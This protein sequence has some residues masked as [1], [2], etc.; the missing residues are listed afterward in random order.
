M[1]DNTERILADIRRTLDETK[2]ILL[3]V[4]QDRIL[5]VKKRL[6]P[7]GTVKFQVYELCDGT[8]STKDIAGALQKSSEYV[9]S[10]LSILRHEG[11]ILTISK[12]GVQV[13]EQVI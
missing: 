13:H 12:D 7:V 2:A 10:Y 1:A 3:L 8:R 6:L 9:N 5:E 11:L 4:N